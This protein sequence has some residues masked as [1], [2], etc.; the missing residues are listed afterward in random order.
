LVKLLGRN[1]LVISKW[2]AMKENI[3]IEVIGWCGLGFRS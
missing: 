1:N 3:G 2:S